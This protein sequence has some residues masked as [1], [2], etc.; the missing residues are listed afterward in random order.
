MTR[1]R[2]EER[3]ADVRVQQLERLIA[4]EVDLAVAQY[5]SAQ[6]TLATVESDML[7]QARDVRAIT[8]YAYRRGQASLIE[9]LDAQRAF[10]ET[11]QAWNEARAEYARSVF[12]VRAS[13][14][15]VTIP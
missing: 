10:N 9:L 15:E 6:V 3:Q 11:M 4:S 12:L 2:H 5:A 13:V 14:G 8:D 7:T 1:S